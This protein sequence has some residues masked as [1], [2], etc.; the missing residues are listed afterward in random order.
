MPIWVV[1]P[2]IVHK[3]IVSNL[4]AYHFGFFLSSLALRAGSD[5]LRAWAVLVI[6]VG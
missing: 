4:S 2:G 1:T 6:H 3:P 5:R